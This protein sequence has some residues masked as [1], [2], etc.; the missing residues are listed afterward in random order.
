MIGTR[1]EQ[2]EI[3]AHLGSGGMGHVYQASDSRLGRSVA[4][5]ILPDAFVQDADRAARFEREARVLASLNHPNI[6]ALYGLER[7]EGRTFLVMELVP[8]E[9]LADRIAGARPALPLDETVSIAR[10][11]A[12]ALANAHQN[13]VVHRDLK[14]AN[15]KITPTG[16]VKV[17]DFGLAKVLASSEGKVD[18]SLSPTIT[19]AA[20]TRAGLIL[21]T[22]AYMSP[23]QAKGLEADKR[24]DI[25]A[26]GCVLFEMLAG[27]RPFEAPDVA[28][29]LAAVILREPD[30]A[31]LPAGVPPSIRRLAR[32]CLE[33]DRT[34]RM[35]DIAGAIFALDD[36]REVSTTPAPQAQRARSGRFAAAGWIAAALIAVASAVALVPVL[37]RGPAEQPT[38]HLQIGTP[39]GDP[40]TFALSPDGRSMVFQA[41]VDGRTQL[42]LRRFETGEDRPLAD[43]DGGIHPWWSPD[44]LSVAF[45]ADGLIKRI[46]LDSGFVR[47]VATAPGNPRPGAWNRDGTLLVSGASGPVLKLSAEGGAIV[48]PATEMLP[49]QSSHR[50]AQFLP[51]GRRFLLLALGNEDAKGIYLGSLDD[52]AITRVMDGEPPFSFLPPDL[53]LVARQGAIWAQRLDMASGKPEGELQPAAPRVL[54]DGQLNGLVAL[55]TSSSGSVAYRAAAATR[56]LLWLDRAGRQTGPLGEPDESQM[57]LTGS[58]PDGRTLVLQRTLDGNTDLWLMDTARGTLTRSTVS[59]AVDGSAILSPDGSRVVYASDPKDTLWDIYERALDKTGGESPVLVSPENEYPFDWSPDGRHVLFGMNG[60]KS[61]RDIWVL[62]MSGDRKPFAVV[63]APSFEIGSVFSPSG[64]WIAFVSN[65]SGRNEVYAQPFPGPGAKMQI[66]VGGGSGLRWPRQGR[67]LFYVAPDNELMAVEVSEQGSTLMVSTPRRVLSLLPED[68]Y[69]PSPDGQRFV[70]NRIVSPPPPISI[71]LNWKPP[72]R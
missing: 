7:S 59:P 46:D 16:M 28:E 11:I 44:S 49:G 38:M 31:R 20:M 45:F 24:S 48:E 29:T 9:T 22:A 30:W 58:S 72:Q 34:K 23:E 25:W 68:E 52:T 55:S 63:Q 32:S 64:R 43:T 65:E 53:L 41:K 8:G 36:A 12:E 10:Q 18:S 42:W 17:L 26:F 37:R 40:F 19:N 61:N 60:L 1:I 15:I 27:S 14:P 21:G 56:Q 70:V 66:S 13:G 33:R 57:E 69:I 4:I 39:D 3:T 67:E 5:K 2:Y 50:F 71:I 35:T 47:R 51:D 54:V 62:P 6:A